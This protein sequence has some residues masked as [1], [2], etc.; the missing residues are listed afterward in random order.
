MLVPKLVDMEIPSAS[1]L[2]VLHREDGSTTVSVEADVAELAMKRYLRSC[3][4]IAM[5]PRELLTEPVKLS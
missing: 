1:T 4:V 3:G 2:I 5:P